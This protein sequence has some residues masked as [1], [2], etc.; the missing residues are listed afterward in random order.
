[1]GNKGYYNGKR[2]ALQWE[3]R[4][5]AAENKKRLAAPVSGR[6]RKRRRPGARLKLSEVR[7]R[8]K[9]KEDNGQ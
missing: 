8:R 1:M 6:E 7:L 5:V 2:G 9:L 3:K 4:G